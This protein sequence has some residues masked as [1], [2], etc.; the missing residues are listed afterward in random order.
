MPSMLLPRIAIEI[1]HE[2]GARPDQT[3]IAFEHIPE[4]RQL[5]QGSRTE[6]PS[7]RSQPLRIR[8]EFAVRVPGIR[9][10]PE[11]DQVE[12]DSVMSRPRLQK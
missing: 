9:H 6:P 4:L 7:E 1:L 3:H 11:L 5:I 10:G 12:D 8:Q 2:Q